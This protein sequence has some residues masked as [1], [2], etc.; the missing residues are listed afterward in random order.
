M[1]DS[2]RLHLPKE[3]CDNDLQQAPSG[4][5][6]N[7]LHSEDAA[8]H[9]PSP[10]DTIAPAGDDLANT[11]IRYITYAWPHLQPHV[12]EAI[13]TL[14]DAALPDQHRLEGGQS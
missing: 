14:I 3:L 9:Q 11:S 13:F 4:L 5:A 8:S 1:F 10:D 7:G 2:R 12:R 6:V